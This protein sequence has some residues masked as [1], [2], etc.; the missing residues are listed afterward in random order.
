MLYSSSHR[1]LLILQLCLVHL[2]IVRWLRFANCELL[3]Q[4]VDLV[5][6]CIVRNTSITWLCKQ[7]IPRR[8]LWG[9]WRPTSVDQGT[10]VHNSTNECSL[11][12]AKTH[13][14]IEWNA[15]AQYTD[16]N[17]YFIVLNSPSK[18]VVLLWI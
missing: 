1:F 18:L 17:E 8:I 4:K 16:T 14:R 9:E 15:E 5:C 3:H 7:R 10:A 6:S 13:S 11:S 12:A 2:S